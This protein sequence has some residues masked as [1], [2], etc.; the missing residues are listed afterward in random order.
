MGLSRY[1]MDTTEFSGAHLGFKIHFFLSLHLF[2]VG[3]LSQRRTIAF[4]HEALYQTSNAKRF[5]K[6][7]SHRTC[8]WFSSIALRMVD[9]I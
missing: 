2:V 9:M 4:E 5:C 3:I 1:R 8:I 7:L 6:R